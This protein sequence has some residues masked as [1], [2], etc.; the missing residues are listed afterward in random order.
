MLPN[1]FSEEDAQRYIAEFTSWPHKFP[2]DQLVYA[3]FRS[4]ATPSVADRVTCHGCNLTLDSFWTISNPL[5]AHL[6]K[7]RPCPIALAIQRR[8]LEIEEDAEQKAKDIIQTTL[9]QLAQQSEIHRGNVQARL[10]QQQTSLPSTKKSTPLETK[11]ARLLQFYRHNGQKKE[12]NPWYLGNNTPK[13]MPQCTEASTRVSSAIDP[14]LLQAITAVMEKPD[15]TNRCRVLYDV[16]K[17]VSVGG[18]QYVI[19]LVV[20]MNTGT[21]GDEMQVESETTSEGILTPGT[22][23]VDGQ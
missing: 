18:V 5:K 2:P 21:K 7:R 10:S 8:G 11:E 4:A 16:D 22:S 23:V 13:G 17:V 9:A 14:K 20:K 19:G 6:E 12:S 1:P 3:G 15:I